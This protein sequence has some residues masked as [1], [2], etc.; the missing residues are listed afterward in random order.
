MTTLPAI[1]EPHFQTGSVAGAAQR[2]CRTQDLPKLAGLWPHELDDTSVS[3]RT[4]LI[5][6][7]KRAL[8]DERLRGLRGHWTYNLARHCQLLAAYKCEVAALEALCHLRNEKGP[9]PR[10]ALKQLPP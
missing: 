8:R 7:L 2:Y 6:K 3:G 1:G 5:A 9:A 4:R 10:Q